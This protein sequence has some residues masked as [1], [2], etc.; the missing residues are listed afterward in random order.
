MRPGI[1]ALR[2]IS[3]FVSLNDDQLNTLNEISDFARIGPREDLFASEAVPT[4]VS[5][6][7]SGYVVA[8]HP[9]RKGI[10]MF[11][12]VIGPVTAIGFAAALL[13]LPSPIGARTI[14]STHLIMVPACGLRKMIDQDQ[15]LSRQ[16]L[17]HALKETHDL[18]NECQELKLR[19]SAQRL[20]RY[21]VALAEET[22]VNTTRLVLPFEKR[23]L[24]AKIG[25]SQE[26][27]SRAF[28]QLRAHG[29]RTSQRGDVVI[30]DAEQ[31]RAYAELILT[32][33]V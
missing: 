11:T 32:D 21:L 19:P 26:N 31:L 22:D 12:D 27:L 13:E 23:F 18:T 9:G 29:V 15:H 4:E 10:V 28:A 33:E 25:C 17:H 2:A 20:A 24:A 3:L 16:F 7:L 6:L 30:N 5:F 1:D 8:N 14:T